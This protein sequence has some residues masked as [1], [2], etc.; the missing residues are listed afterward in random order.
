MTNIEEI[1]ASVSVNER[2][3]ISNLGRIRS[4]LI[5]KRKRFGEFRYPKGWITNYGYV[6]IRIGNNDFNVHRLVGIAF[7]PNPENK[8]EI[9]HKNG[10]KTDNKA[11]NLEWV[12]KQEN[13]KHAHDIGLYPIGDKHPRCKIS[14]ETISKIRKL[15][16]SGVS[17]SD[18]HKSFGI[19][20][21]MISAYVLNKKR[22]EKCFLK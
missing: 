6:K 22:R 17:Q 1:W 4:K 8:S 11:S 14:D 7:I 13:I 3:E 15:F 19:S 20:R 5:D 12:T 18:L 21:S 16:N 10:I 9:N 2:Y